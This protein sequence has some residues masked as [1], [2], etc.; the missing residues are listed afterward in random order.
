MVGTMVEMEASYLTAEYFRLIMQSGPEGG[1][2]LRTLSGKLVTEAVEDGTPE[3]RHLKTIA[4]HVSGYVNMVCT[5]LKHT[6]PKAIVHCLVCGRVLVERSLW[7]GSGWSSRVFMTIV[8]QLYILRMTSGGAVQEQA[9][10]AHDSQHCGA[11]R[12]GAAP[13]VDGG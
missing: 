1:P 8:V 5:Q 9:A 13:C 7:L 10:G 4:A 2:I 3:E 11:G 12:A 6:I